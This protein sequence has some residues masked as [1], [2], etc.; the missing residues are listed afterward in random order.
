MARGRARTTSGNRRIWPAE[1]A[2]TGAQ[3]TDRSTQRTNRR[4]HLEIVRHLG[5]GGSI[6]FTIATEVKVGGDV[7]VDLRL[8]SARRLAENAA[9]LVA[10]TT[11]Q[12]RVL[13][14]DA[15]IEVAE[16]GTE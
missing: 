4:I 16:D 6:G 15:D 9:V 8:K 13:N 1:P 12:V 5:D 10:Q 14:I 7:A 11:S 3:K 2:T